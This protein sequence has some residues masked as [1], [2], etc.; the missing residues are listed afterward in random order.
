MYT[1]AD[2]TLRFKGGLHIHTNK[3][4]GLKSPAEAAELYRSMGYD[5]IALTDHWIFSEGGDYN[6]LTI[7]SGVEYDV[8][9]DIREG[10]FHIV[11]I[12]CT[13]D[14][15]LTRE[16]TGMAGS[17]KK[18]QYVIDSINDAGGAAILAHPVWSVNRTADI[19]LLRGL[20]GIEIYN[21][22]SGMPWGNRADSSAILDMMA[23]DGLTFPVHASDDTHYYQNELGSSYIYAKALSA[24][25]GDLSLAIKDGDVYASRG[26]ILDITRK[27][28]TLYVTCSP[29][30]AIIFQTGTVWIPD[31]IKKG[32]ALTH[33]EYTIRP[34]DIFVRIEAV[35][36]K[37]NTAWSGYYV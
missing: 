5:F 11:G 35:D 24:S 20:A 1:S 37:G 9:S 16:K 15:A 14:P 2:C 31:R 22:V 3:S 21:A 18:A 13:K 6:G 33:A 25:R 26:P 23:A 36:E 32:D 4:D 34:T 28:N 8:G 17:L 10:I 29:V 19:M 27:N 30:S 7:L 12:G